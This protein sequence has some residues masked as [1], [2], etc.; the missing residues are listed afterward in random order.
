M[1]TLISFASH[2]RAG[3]ITARV[4]SPLDLSYE[5]TLVLYTSDDGPTISP[6]AELTYSD[7]TTS[8]TVPY[9][10]ATPVGNDV[11]IMIFKFFKTWGAPGNYT[12][13]YQEF[14]R[15]GGVLNMNNSAATAFY[16]ETNVII[17]PFLGSPN[18]SSELTVPPI[19][20]G[21]TNQIYNYN[22]GAFDADGDSIAYELVTPLQDDNLT[23][24]NYQDPGVT[25][26]TGGSQIFN[27]DPVTGTLTWDFP[28]RAGLYNIAY[29]IKEYRN[30]NLIGFIHRDMQIII[31][32]NNN[33]KPE[34]ALPPEACYIAGSTISETITASDADG[35]LIELSAFGGVM[36]STGSLA[37]FN[38]NAPNPP[39]T[40]LFTWVPSCNDIRERPYQVVFKADDGLSRDTSLVDIETWEIRVFGP[41][42]LNLTSTPNDG[43][44]SITLNWNSY[45]C[46]NAENIEIWRKDCSEPT[47]IDCDDNLANYGYVKVGTAPTN[48]TSYIDDDNG[49]GLKNGRSYCYRL[50]ARFPAPKGG[51]SIPSN[52]TC[53]YTEDEEPFMLNVDVNK[54]SFTNGEIFV[55][56]TNRITG[57][58]APEYRVYRAEGDNP[59]DADY[60]VLTTTLP[61]DTSF[62][63]ANLNTEEKQYSYKVQITGGK[64]SDHASSV[65]LSS[66]ADSRRINL[67]WDA[68]VPWSNTGGLSHYIYRKYEAA[69]DTDFILI[70]SVDVYNASQMVYVDTGRYNNIA[71]S[72]QDS[73]CYYVVTQG[74]YCNSLIDQDEILL[75]KSQ[76]ICDLPIDITGPCPPQL[77]VDSDCEDKLENF[78]TWE[79]LTK[80]FPCADDIAYYEIHRKT[81]LTDEFSLLTTTADTSFLHDSLTFVTGCYKVRAVDR[82]GNLGVFSDS[83]CV[84]DCPRFDLPNV[85][86]PNGDLQN[87]LFKP[88]PPL[89]GVKE[90]VLTVYNRWG[91]VVYEYEGDPQINWD[92]EGL[93]DG[94][95]YYKVQVEFYNIEETKTVLNGWVHI[96]R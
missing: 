81:L 96:I 21:S 22:P 40:G 19:D 38:Q 23:V 77:S 17:D 52:E 71:L 85:F 59:A 34:L 49:N 65:W 60:Q 45:S 13:S 4:L 2:I 58:T 32:D 41:A 56:W 5:Y 67:S 73:V 31:Y 27:L 55:R 88:I 47:T 39:A 83:I 90:V 20:D 29:R 33:I 14:N 16:I 54:T 93:N 86:T 78:L 62:T 28:I 48:A 82:S 57:G 84:N 91:R 30:G 68:N 75:N 42:P 12:A 1:S 25:N 8:P 66:K 53:E 35:D 51:V 9:T 92:G 50:V 6:E 89:R 94:I 15:V 46:P 80:P 61:N 3:E 11:T 87:S 63:D 36:S 69:G 37:S 95:Y 72:D 74:T 18:N 64:E 24:F 43:N 76:R 26:F 79:P 7:G 10:S 44:S 70:D